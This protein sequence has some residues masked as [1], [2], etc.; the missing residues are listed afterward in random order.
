MNNTD[1]ILEILKQTY[2]DAAPELNFGNAYELLVAVTL[3]AQCTDKRVNSVT[4]ALF[5]K[6]PTPTE[7]ANANIEELENIIRS[8]GFYHSKA[9]SLKETAEKLVES[10]GGQVPSSLDELRTLR[11]V[12][13]KTANVVYAVAFGGD[14]IA[15][16]THVFRV[17]NRL[18]LASAKTVTDTE[19]QL[20]QAIPKD[21]WSLSHHLLIFH[22]RRICKA[23]KPKCDVCPLSKCCKYFL[24]L[25]GGR[26]E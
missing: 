15:V 5:A 18:G 11:G 4:P 13:R 25:Q 6:Y 2:P 16:D 10:Y 7:M 1:T 26:N 19:E 17:S 14:A 22:G 23:V 21:M 9:R 3:S 12:G 24:S 8:V 20:M